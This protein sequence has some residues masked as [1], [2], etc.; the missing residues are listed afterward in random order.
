M[1]YQ[2]TRNRDFDPFNT[3]GGILDTI[4]NEVSENVESGVLR[5]QPPI[6]VLESDEAFRLEVLAPGFTKEQFHINLEN[7]MLLISAEPTAET[8]G[9]KVRRREYT[10]KGFKRSFRLP[11]SA[12]LEAIKA[13]YENGVLQ[14]DVPK[15]KEEKTGGKS[16]VVE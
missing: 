3:F 5:Q 6:N 14:L 12:D 10:L 2:K 4:L 11:K 13:H 1:T 16:I 8:E 15:K 9:W 7:G